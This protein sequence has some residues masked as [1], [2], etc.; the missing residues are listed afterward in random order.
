[1]PTTLLWYILRDMGKTFLLAATGLTLLL[2]L[3]GGVNNL[4]KGEG[5]GT[6]EVIQVLSFVIPGAF[7]L[8][9]PVA[10]L[11]SAAMTYGRL[12]AD[13]ELN[14]CR[15]GG[16]NVHFLLAPVLGLGLIIAMTTFWFSNFVIPGYIKN[17]N[18]IVGKN[19]FRIVM[20]ELRSSGVFEFRGNVIH[21]DRI[22]VVETDEVDS[23]RSAQRFHA[24]R[25]AFMELKG[26]RPIR[27]AT[28]EGLVVE[29]DTVDG[30]PRIRAVLT[31]VRGIDL[32]KNQFFE[33]E[34][35][36]FGPVRIPP[37]GI[38]LKPKWMTLGELRHF[39]RHPAELTVVRDAL[40]GLRSLLRKYLFY[41]WIAKQLQSDIHV[42]RFGN[43]HLWYE[44]RAEK[45]AA[46]RMTARPRLHNPR[47]VE[48]TPQRTRE[49]R[50]DSG[51]IDVHGFPNDETP[52]GKIDLE[53]NI[54]II[55]SADPDQPI[56]K[57]R[58]NLAAVEIPEEVMEEERAYKD[59]VLLDPD[60]ELG[61][62]RQIDNVRAGMLAELKWQVL[63]IGSVLHS[64]S[65]FSVSVLP[66]MLLG[67]CLGVVFRGGHVMT[68]FGISFAPALF[69]IAT[70]AMGRQ[71]SE[72][73]DTVLLG[74]MII[75]GAV[76]AVAAVDVLVLYRGVRR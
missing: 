63:R 35:Q 11:F 71:V 15:A 12:T 67:A 8:S 76:V 9:L 49:I 57:A 43:E 69:V 7:T 3:G 37:I 64:R 4:L 47:V 52:K 39:S 72:H 33:S 30:A 45:F 61:M 73:P 10:G 29:F 13:N 70:I 28:T 66:T 48:H 42:A 5:M 68:A 2:S 75:W 24:R 1:M 65:A 20:G 16:V 22:D 59:S 56:R 21:V 44:I 51:T 55:D 27:V 58:L 60:R 38:S 14:A 26:D 40:G 23:E 36:P 19:A 6:V 17:L 54:A 41:M 25:G 50:A 31:K 53:G 46:D 32:E 74:D 18:E 34:E 62:G